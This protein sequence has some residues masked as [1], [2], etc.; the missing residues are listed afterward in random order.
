MSTFNKS[1]TRSICA[2]LVLAIA[3]TLVP[4]VAAQDTSLSLQ[5]N[6]HRVQKWLGS[7][8]RAE[9]WR[10]YLNLGDLESQS[11]LGLNADLQML[12]EIEGNFQ[13]GEP[14]L[15]H[16]YFAA[17]GDAISDQ[18]LTIEEGL[19]AADPL[20]FDY[21]NSYSAISDERLEETRAKLLGELVLLDQYY[22]E[23]LWG[24]DRPLVL[25]DLKLREAI[26]LLQSIS[27]TDPENTIEGDDRFDQRQNK[28]L[29]LA[30]FLRPLKPNYRIYSSQQ[31]NFHIKIVEERL[32]QFDRLL[33]QGFDSNTS[34]TNY[35]N[36]IGEFGTHLINLNDP[37]NLQAQLKVSQGLDDLQRFD[38][39][40]GLVAGIRQRYSK[41]NFKLRVTEEAI[42]RIANQ[43]P[44]YD[45]RYVDQVVLG[46][47]IQG[48]AYTNGNV[49][50][51]LI[52]DPHQGHISI[53]LNGTVTSDGKTKQGPI[54][55]Y[56]STFAHVEGRRSL[57]V[58]V[59]GLMEFA[60]YVAASLSSNFHGTNCSLGLVNRIAVSEYMKKKHRSE[61]I[62]AR[63]L[64]GQLLEQFTDQT[65]DAISQGKNSIIDA[66]I[67]YFNMLNKISG[68]R[69]EL[70]E[71][72]VGF[73]DQGNVVEVNDVMSPIRVPEGHISTSNSELFV[74][75]FL[76]GGNRLG[77]PSPPPIYHFPA[78]IRT[79]IHESMLNN[80][81][82]PFV[83]GRKYTSEEITRIMEGLM[84]EVPDAI[85]ADPG[86][87]FEITFERGLP[88]QIQFI[89]QRIVVTLN[90]ANFKQDDINTGP[91]YIRTTLKM[92]Q[93]K[94]QLL[95][96]VDGNPEVDFQDPG[97]KTLDQIGI[98]TQIREKL[99]ENVPDDP[100]EQA[101]EI[102]RNLIPV[103]LLGEVNLENI[104]L[105]NDIRLVQFRIENGWLT[106]G[107]DFKPATSSF[108]NIAAYAMDTPAIHSHRSA[109]D[110]TDGFTNLD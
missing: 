110:T 26:E 36:A 38:Q 92:I 31:D 60:P 37:L 93:N 52:N 79:Q 30:R 46:N 32:E 4:T 7:G 29:A 76:E 107:W 11:A 44:V 47:R 75:G 68:F 5:Q 51:D 24:I 34:Q 86:Q 101:I 17:L 12:R 13:T 18:I 49:F 28:I 22:R 96:I 3:L 78:D 8:P 23:N 94:G 15:A 41:P 16:P 45:S 91:M 48:F 62:G 73:D 55:A 64:E 42:N 39:H 105:E 10:R 50:I 59:G 89:N 9:G 85:A 1:M 87:N 108:G 53:N 102:P 66:H 80:I 106:I 72:S 65:E 67:Q 14:G 82:G 81:A 104:D 70:A 74:T 63:I 100:L 43:P 83:D 56:S 6:L 21:A 25:K 33:T 57:F 58:N 88:I 95:L 35:T 69:Y 27:F 98:R 61:G 2:I 84:G 99:A 97:E 19:Q 71:A 103:D 20:S 109:P 54:T 40:P 90:A 77:A